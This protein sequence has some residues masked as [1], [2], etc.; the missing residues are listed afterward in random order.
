MQDMKNKHQQQIKEN[1][2]QMKSE[3]AALLKKCDTKISTNDNKNQNEIKRI[4]K[5]MQDLQTEHDKKINQSKKEMQ[6]LKNK[7]DEKIK[8]IKKQMQDQKEQHERKLKE[9]EAQKKEEMKA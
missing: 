1:E 7:H 3:I 8:E 4:E 9:N 2:D 5:L 6:D